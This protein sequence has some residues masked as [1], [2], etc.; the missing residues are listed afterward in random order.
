MSYVLVRHNVEEFSKWKSLYDKHSETRKA[1]GSKGAR[2]FRNANNPNEA[3][4]LFEWNDIENAR[5]FTQSD[6]LRQRMQ[7]AGVTGKPDIF[8]LDEVERTPA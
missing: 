3:V 6:D 7:E 5:K 4:L 2:V 1:G 8:F